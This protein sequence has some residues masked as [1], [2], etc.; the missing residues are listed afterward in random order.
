MLGFNRDTGPKPKCLVTTTKLS[1]FLN[2][3]QPPTKKR[4]F[5]T[6]LGQEFVHTLDLLLPA[7]AASPLQETLKNSIGTL[8][9]SKLHLKPLD[10]LTNPF[11]TTYIKS[12]GS[13]VLLL[14]Q[15]RPGID[16][17]FSLSSGI[18][19]LEID[20]ATFQKL[21]LQGKVIGPEK[22]LGRKH[23]KARYAIEV[24]L[25]APGMVQGKPGFER[26][27][28]AFKNVLNES[29]T[30]L[31]CDL[32][33]SEEESGSG[34]IEE[35]AP[36]VRRVEAE[37]EEI[38]NAF[39]PVMPMEIK[40]EEYAESAEILEWITMAMVGSEGV[41]EGNGVDSVFSRYQVPTSFGEPQVGGLV[42]LRWRGLVHGQFAYNVLL[43]AMKASGDQWVA[44]TG[45]AFAGDAYTILIKEGHSTT[46][47]YKD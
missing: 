7:S 35:F 42:R 30:W 40:E 31:F 2:H 29:L 13:N 5:S 32:S 11:F 20:K 10:L 27:V 3:E 8:T 28:W 1:N 6:V 17:L 18:L 36:Q 43:A 22:T 47:E 46:W 38:E 45:T 14:S 33:G 41:R 23:V 15:G 25:R 19:R 16:P 4:P 26:I 12:P 21:G 34:V 24:N 39:V 44:M 37:V 9:Y